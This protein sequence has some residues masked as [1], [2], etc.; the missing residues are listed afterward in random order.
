MKKSINMLTSFG[1][2]LQET[3]MLESL[4]N[5]EYCEIFQGTYFEEHLQKVTSQNGFVKIIHSRF[6]LP[7]KKRVFQHQYQK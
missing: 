4:F 6:N 2:F 5:Y 7:L 1:C 3:P